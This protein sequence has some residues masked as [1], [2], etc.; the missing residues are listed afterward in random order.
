M[1]I[2]DLVQQCI[3]SI[4]DLI[5]CGYSKVPVVNFS[6]K[7]FPN[8]N[9]INIHILLLIVI[10]FRFTAKIIDVKTAFFYEELEEKIYIKCLQ[11]MPSNISKV[12]QM[13][14]EM[15]VSFQTSASIALFRQ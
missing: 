12:C 9:D 1:D 13:Y 3:S 2:Q 10:Y 5:T 15:A 4:F 7:C 6:K 8:V 11:G 14:V